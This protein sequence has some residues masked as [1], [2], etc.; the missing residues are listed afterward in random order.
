M[1]IHQQNQFHLKIAT[2]HLIAGALFYDMDEDIDEIIENIKQT[3][4][5][6]KY[7]WEVEKD[8]FHDIQK[9]HPQSS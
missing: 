4:D 3:C 8:T 6:Y 9:K 2:S 5:D 7:Q 1:D